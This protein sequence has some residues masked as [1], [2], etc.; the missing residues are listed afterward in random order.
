M[1]ENEGEKAPARTGSRRF[2]LLRARRNPGR[3]EPVVRYGGQAL[4]GVAAG[5]A[6]VLLA[7]TVVSLVQG[8]DANRQPPN[9][10]ERPYGEHLAPACAEDPRCQCVNP[11]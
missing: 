7:W 6:G 8:P 11:S 2:P 4:Y 1:D 10:I 5:L 3:W 9:R